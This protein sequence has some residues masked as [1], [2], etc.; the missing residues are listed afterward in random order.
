[1]KIILLSIL[2]FFVSKGYSQD[3]ITVHSKQWAGGICCSSGTDFYVSFPVL[4]M[5]KNIDSVQILVQGMVIHLQGDNF[6]TSGQ[7]CSFNFGWSNRNYYEPGGETTSYYGIRQNQISAS[8][9]LK[10]RAIFFYSK[11]IKNEAFVN[12]TEDYI[13]YP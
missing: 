8:E 4:K 6:T 13:A 12:F 5:A 1:M 2:L 10:N 7:T 11:G 9:N 3:T